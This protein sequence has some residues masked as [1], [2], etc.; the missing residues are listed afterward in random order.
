MGRRLVDASLPVPRAPGGVDDS[1]PRV[2]VTPQGTR[3][4]ARWANELV[5]SATRAR[6]L[7]SP[8][9]RERAVALP[10]ALEAAREAIA[11]GVSVAEALRS[12]KQSL[13]DAGFLKVDYLALVDVVTLEP[14]D[15]FVE[16]ARLIDAASVGTVRLIDNIAV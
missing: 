12:A 15:A 10:H 3:V 7:L 16:G 4:R 5:A 8:D 6:A 2:Q 14:L 1:E 11:G 9:E 13:M